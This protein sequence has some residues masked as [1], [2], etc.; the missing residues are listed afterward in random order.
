M[1]MVPPPHRLSIRIP[2]I[3]LVV[4]A[5][6]SL[7]GC[8]PDPEDQ[9]QVSEL[10]EFDELS[11][12]PEDAVILRRE[13]QDPSSDLFHSLE[14]AIRIWVRT[15]LHRPLPLIDLYGDELEKRGWKRFD[16]GAAGPE[17]EA[18]YWRKGDFRL[19]ISVLNPDHTDFSSAET[20]AYWSGPSTVYRLTLAAEG[21]KAD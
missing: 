8:G 2:L 12:L 3:P 17:L 7:V 20:Q 11:I 16:L 1:S 6:M 13:E 10:R 4:L 14:A 5:A 15:N 19:Q 9:Y 21:D 18:E